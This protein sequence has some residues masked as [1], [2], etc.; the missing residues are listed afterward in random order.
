MTTYC[1][2]SEL[3]GIERVVTL[4]GVE[5]ATCGLGNRRSIHLSYRATPTILNRNLE[6]AVPTCPH[7]GNLFSSTDARRNHGRSRRF[8]YRG[9]V[10]FLFRMRCAHCRA[11]PLFPCVARN[12]A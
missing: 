12:C 11:S 4:A 6:P 10:A 3:R 8:K 2:T 1:A 7:A 9:I 5:P